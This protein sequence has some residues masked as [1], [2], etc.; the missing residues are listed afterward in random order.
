LTLGEDALVLSI[1]GK[2]HNIG[3]LFMFFLVRLQKGL[4]LLVIVGCA[5]DLLCKRRRFDFSF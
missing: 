3:E 5:L 4:E 1:V 2:V